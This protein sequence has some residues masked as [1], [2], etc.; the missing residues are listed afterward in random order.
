MCIAQS[1]EGVDVEVTCRVN[2]RIEHHHSEGI[3]VTVNILRS[4]DVTTS[5]RVIRH[6][7]SDTV[8]RCREIRIHHQTALVALPVVVV[9]EAHVLCERRLQAGVTLADVQRVRVVGN[10]QQVAHGWLTGVGTIGQTQLADIRNLPTEVGSRSEIGHCTGRVR[11]Y[12]LIILNEV[13]L[14]RYHLYTNVEVVCITHHAQH[15]L[16][17]MDIVFVFRVA[18]QVSRSVVFKR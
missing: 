14:L 7:T 11:V 1:R 6:L 8:A 5:C 15:D 4:C 16:G 17:C 12:A 9:L 3:P 13:R 10:V 2:R 18:A